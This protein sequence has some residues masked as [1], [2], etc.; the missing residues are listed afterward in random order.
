MIARYVIGA[1]M[2]AMR[3]DRDAAARVLND[4]ARAA[5]TL[6]LPRLTAHVENERM[7]LALPLADG[8][9]RVRHEEALL[10]DGLREITA[11]LRD[12]TEIRGLLAAQP[13]LACRRAQAWVQRLQHQGRPRALLQANRLLVVCLS[14]AGRIDE[15]KQTLTSL[16]AQ[17]AELGL[18]RYLLDD[19][20]DL[21]AALAAL[22]DDLHGD[23]W[24]PTWPQVPSA[25]LDRIVSEA[26]LVS[27]G[28]AGPPARP[29]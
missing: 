17:C 19:G 7:R 13:D 10:G 22:R 25:F 23:Q 3:G 27:S 18:V 26:H 28:G 6:S 11:Q 20:P 1:R 16:A 24:N 4:G 2:K 5:A 8:P 12:E 21:I 29:D 9:T 14:A 15:A